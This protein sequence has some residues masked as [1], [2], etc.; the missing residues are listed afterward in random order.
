ML[1]FQNAP[2]NIFSFKLTQNILY[3]NAFFYN[4]TNSFKLR[5]FSNGKRQLLVVLQRHKTLFIAENRGALSSIL[6]F[7][8]W[9]KC[10]TQ[11]AYHTCF[12]DISVCKL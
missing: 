3:T 1:M 12:N 4:Y 7:N 2:Y 11:T 9:M 10:L 5:F 6:H 8:T